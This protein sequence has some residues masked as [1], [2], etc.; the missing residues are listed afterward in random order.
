MMMQADIARIIVPLDASAT[1]ERA[2]PVAEG[3]AA[4][5][6][7]EI[8]YFSAARDAA[9]EVL[10]NEYLITLKSRSEVPIGDVVVVLSEH[11]ADAIAAR[12]LDVGPSIVCMATHG[13]NRSSALIGSVTTD[14]VETTG[15]PVIVVGPY[16][17]PGPKAA[18]VVACVDGSDGDVVVAETAAM[19]AAKLGA[20]LLVATVVEPAPEPELIGA[21]HLGHRLSGGEASKYVRKLSESPLADGLVTNSIVI[22]NPMSPIDGLLDWFVTKRAQLLVVG[23]RQESRLSRAL[24]GSTAASIVHG[25][26]VPVLYV[27]RA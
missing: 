9:E 6:G 4:T 10:L 5:L 15:C 19:W 11:P 22:N 12:Q 13:R 24:V 23:S 18:P 21:R 20:E 8:E 25:S 27:R 1:A 3:L 17:A 2:L 26:L 7:V 14:L 16:A